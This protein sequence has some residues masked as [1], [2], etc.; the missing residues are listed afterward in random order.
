MR[1]KKFGVDAFNSDAKKLVRAERFGLK[2]SSM[3][4]IYVVVNFRSFS[5]I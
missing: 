3:N 5:N 4:S 2:N 1:A